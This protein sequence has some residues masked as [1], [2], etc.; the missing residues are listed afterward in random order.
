[1]RS[2]AVFCAWV[3]VAVACLVAVASGWSGHPLVPRG[4]VGIVF[5]GLMLPPAIVLT[6]RGLHGLFSFDTAAS[7]QRFAGVKP[8]SVMVTLCA[9]AYFGLCG[10]LLATVC[11]GTLTPPLIAAMWPAASWLL[12]HEAVRRQYR[13]THSVQTARGAGD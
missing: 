8:G 6:C 11:F 2:F 5:M 9:E 4:A 13:R 1:L 7:A 12:L 10:I 3:I